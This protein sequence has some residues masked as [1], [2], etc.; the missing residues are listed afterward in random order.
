MSRLWSGTVLL[1]LSLLLGAAVAHAAPAVPRW[2]WSSPMPQGEALQAVTYGDG[3]FVAVGNGGTILTSPD[4]TAWKL[5]P[6]WFRESLHGVAY[7]AGRFVAV[8]AAGRIATS[9][10]GA[11]WVTRPSPTRSRLNGVTYTGSRFVAVGDGGA[12]LVSEDGLQW[13]SLPGATPFNLYAVAYGGGRYMAAGELGTVLTS[14]DGTAWSRIAV[15]T[16]ADLRAAAYGGG[17]MVIAGDGGT[18]LAGADGQELKL[19]SAR[20]DGLKAVAYGA[21]RFVAAGA[22]LALSVLEAPWTIYRTLPLDT[23]LQMNGVAYGGGQFA[24]VGARGLIY[25]SANGI[26]WTAA[27]P[28]SRMDL[29]GLVEGNG[30]FVAAGPSGILTSPDGAAWTERLAA[31]VTAIA[32]GNGTF[33][34]MGQ[35]TFRSFDGNTWSA[36]PFT[37]FSPNA[38]LYGNG[39]FIALGQ[40]VAVSLDGATWNTMA[41]PG[42]RLVAGAYGNGRFAAF[43][44]AGTLFT[45]ADG[46]AWDRGINMAVSPAGIAYGSGRFVFMGGGGSVFMSADGVAWAMQTRLGAPINGLTYAGGQFMAMGDAGVVFTSPDGATWTR[47]S[48]GVTGV[49]RAAAYGRDRLV[50]VGTGGAIL[51]HPGELVAN[52]CGRRFADVAETYPACDSVERLAERAVVNGYPGGS[53]APERQVTRAEFAK[54][55]VAAMGWQPLPGDAMPFSDVKGHWAGAQGYLQAAYKQGVINGFPDGTF[56][57]D[58][59]L[60]R[61]QAIKIVAA[62]ARLRQEAAAGY[63]DVAAGDWYSG[64]VGGALQRHLIGPAAAAPLWDGPVFREGEPVIRGEAAM[65]LANLESR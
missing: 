8:G 43:S 34:A 23:T 56:R 2:Q 6:F 18:I 36:Q 53:F 25:R 44:E 24:G 22:Q 50:A 59:P 3:Q 13:Q 64:W 15:P 20:A 35:Q 16:V 7:G 42:E 27:V 21:G 17:R 12:M 49:L 39:R 10:D 40:K 29:A 60:S 51:M 63:A 45:S 4:G 38:I 19:E 30:R 55:L 32:Y 58:A 41:G 5:R 9:V 54:M 52:P 1:V 61:S 28:A 11:T 62:A 33:V 37:G 47:R 57:P 31:G 46:F 48:T 26:D 65:L 14:L